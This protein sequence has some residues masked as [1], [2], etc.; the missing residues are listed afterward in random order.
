[1]ADGTINIYIDSTFSDTSDDTEDVDVGIR[2]AEADV[3]GAVNMPTVFTTASATDYTDD[4][5]VEVFITSSGNVVSGTEDINTYFTHS[6]TVSGGEDCVTECYIGSTISGTDDTDIVC[7]LGSTTTSGY[8]FIYTGFIAGQTFSGID[9]IPIEVRNWTSYSGIDDS[10]VNYTAGTP[11]D[12]IS[13]LITQASIGTLSSGSINSD[14]DITFAGW[15]LNNIPIDLY[16]GIED[17][18]YVGSEMTVISGGVVGYY[19]DIISAVSGTNYVF[20]DLICGL[21]NTANIDLETTVIS[22]GVDK[23]DTDVWCGVSDTKYIT[24]DVDLLSLYISDLSIAVGEYTLAN[25]FI[26]VDVTDDVHNVVTSG[27]YFM[28]DGTQVSG[29]T[30]SGITDGYRMYYDPSDDF[31]SIEGPITFTV[32]AEN[33]NGDILERDHYITFGYLVSYYPG[34][35]RYDHSERVT[36]RM[37]AENLA[38]CPAFNAE[39][40]WF[41]TRD[42]YNNDLGCFIKGVGVGGDGNLSAS[43]SPI[44][45]AYYYGKV[46]RVIVNARDFAGNAMEPYEFEFEIRNPNE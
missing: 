38:T 25:N 45:N 33:D 3:I 23:V 8:W 13:D 15:V 36:V 12:T 28:I 30:Y 32:H 40:Y 39:G 27:T 9:A 14:V 7:F 18:E 17:T 46:F 43:I 19:T 2:L 44:S 34:E 41:E 37:E 24:C 6:A 21:V 4:F 31:E 42:L 11:I 1:M 35:D 16:S 5:A 26:S 20:V 29:T 10:E 22:G